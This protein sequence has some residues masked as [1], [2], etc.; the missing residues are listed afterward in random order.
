MRFELVVSNINLIVEI[1]II[2]YKGHKKGYD[3]EF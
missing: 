1:E 2:N 3:F